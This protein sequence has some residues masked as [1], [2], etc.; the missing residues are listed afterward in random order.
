[1][2]LNDEQIKYLALKN[3]MITPFKDEKTSVNSRHV[4]VPSYGLS[5]Y[6]YDIRAGETFSTVH[7]FEND[8]APLDPLAASSF[9]LNEIKTFD[10]GLHK[11][12][13]IPPHSF[14]LT[15]SLEYFKIPN[16]V[17]TICVGKS[18]YARCGLIVN[19][20]PFEPGWEGHATLE[21]SNTTNSP[22]V[23]YTEGGIAQ[24]LFFKGNPC[25]TPYD[26]ASQYN[27]QQARI[28]LPGESHV[29]SCRWN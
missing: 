8:T 23:F 7:S 10:N 19:V 3:G 21:I 20:T 18:T 13:I 16:D 22:I 1:M 5:S 6:G 14:V 25:G 24:V 4:K 15:Y 2:I 17:I 11:Y 27:Y 29:D 26:T 9:R 12:A 28:Y